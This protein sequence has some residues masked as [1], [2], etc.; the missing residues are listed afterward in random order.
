MA[1]RKIATKIDLNNKYK[2]LIRDT[3][4]FSDNLFGIVNFPS[5]FT[6]GKNLFKI[7]IDSTLFVE[8][9]QIHIEI[10]DYNGNP[11]YWEPLNYVEK[12]GTRVIAVYIYPDTSPGIATV[13][14]AGRVLQVA[15]ERSSYSRDYNSPNHADI[16]NAIWSRT[17]PIAPFA[18]NDSEIIFT[19]QPTLTINEIVQSYLQPTDVVNVF[20]Q[21]TA[22]NSSLTI[23]P[24]ASSLTSANI[25]KT[26]KQQ[27]PA[28]EG[29]LSKNSPNI[30]DAICFENLSFWYCSSI[31]NFS[32]LIVAKYLL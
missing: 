19:T 23:E 22:S 3:S 17:I 30:S 27:S 24:E 20:T 26:G 32:G 31:I 14:V 6:A 16:P 5:R 21:I 1:I 25:I 11:I 29:K 4:P 8:N 2:Y 15:N 13:Y 10:L 28:T 18:S 12:D 9:S 7:R